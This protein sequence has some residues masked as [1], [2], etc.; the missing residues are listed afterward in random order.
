MNRLSRFRL[1]GSLPAPLRLVLDLEHVLHE[2][3]VRRL[4]ARDDAAQREHADQ[5]AQDRE[6]PTHHVG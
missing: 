5:Q 1:T 3:A 6:A 2:P 4:R